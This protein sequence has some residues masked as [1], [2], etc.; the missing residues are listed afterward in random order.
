MNPT[1]A[2]MPVTMATA[3]PQPMMP[4]SLHAFQVQPHLAFSV[5]VP[6][7]CFP[8]RQVCSLIYL[9]FFCPKL[10]VCFYT[11]LS[12]IFFLTDLFF[13][14]FCRRSCWFCLYIC[15]SFVFVV[16]SLLALPLLKALQCLFISLSHTLTH[17]LW[18]LLT[19]SL[20]VRYTRVRRYHTKV[21]PLHSRLM[22]S[23]MSHIRG[24]R[25]KSQLSHNF[26]PTLTTSL[27]N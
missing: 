18:L 8:A 9:L 5:P 25:V 10:Y 11:F 21:S 24:Q 23:E 26:L 2:L 14:F 27:S 12:Q 16:W 1:A 17:S 13:F 22:H 20:A 15:S 19:C 4:G 3:A 6:L 7:C